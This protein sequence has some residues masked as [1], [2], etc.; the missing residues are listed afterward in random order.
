MNN[1]IGMVIR[2]KGDNMGKS[3]A[4]KSPFSRFDH[5]AVV[6]KDMDKA[7][8][9][10]SSL[11]IGPFERGNWPHIIEHVVRGKPCYARNKVRLAPMGSAGL[12]LIQPLEGETIQREFLQT[13]G[14]GV[15]HLGF[16]VD[17]L[18]KEVDNLIKRGIKVVQ[19]GRRAK[20]GGHAFIEV[21]GI[22]L[23]LTQRW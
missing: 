4:E 18:D 22:I 9:H 7:I 10:F 2:Q 13:K 19:S 1:Q 6:V 16:L 21:G 15:H 8:Q 20:A 14:E 11:G 17:D 23:E 5:V 12:E 3:E